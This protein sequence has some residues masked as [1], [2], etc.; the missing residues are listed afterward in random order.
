[1]TEPGAE[2][3]IETFQATAQGRGWPTKVSIVGTSWTFQVDEPKEDGGSN[4]GPNPMQHFVAALASCQNEQ[5]QVVAEELSIAIEG[6]DI[7]VDVDLN[8]AGFMGVAQDS[9]GCYREA[10]LTAVVHGAVT[11]SQ[12][13]ELGDRVD[14]RCPVLSLLRSSGCAITSS[15]SAA[16]PAP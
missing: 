14:R 8:L 3:H 15:W 4:S 12:V 7:T 9:D 11:E 2:S 6:I 13:R 5:A 10:R 1:M 16:V